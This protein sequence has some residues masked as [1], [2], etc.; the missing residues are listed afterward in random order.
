M[1]PFS[2]TVGIVQLSKETYLVANYIYKTL[3]SA[4]NS[5]EER[6]DVVAQIRREL[7]FFQSFGRYFADPRGIVVDDVDLNEVLFCPTSQFTVQRLLIVCIAALVGRNPGY[8]GANENRFC[9]L[10]TIGCPGGS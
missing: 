3:I 4:R 10:C 5:E 9:R 7:L 1:D 6:R 2:L 8:I